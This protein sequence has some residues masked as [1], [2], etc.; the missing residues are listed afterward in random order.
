[1]RKRLVAAVIVVLL[2]T[3]LTV[4]GLRPLF[5]SK[6]YAGVTIEGVHLGGIGRDE[7]AQLLTLWQKQQQTR[8]IAVYYGDTRFDIDAASIDF[9]LDVDATVEEVWGFGRRGP[10]WERLKNIYTAGTEGY[11]VPARFK[12]NEGKLEQLISEWKETIDRPSR[13]ATF[14][15]LTGGVIPQEPGRK[16][17]VTALKPMLIKALKSPDTSSVALPVTPVYP[18]I[19]VADITQTGIKESMSLYSTNFNAKEANRTT[20]IRMAARKIN[21]HIVYPGQVFS[22]NET[23]GPRDL[24]HGFKEALEIVDGEFVPGI[25]GGVCQVSS[26]LYNAVLLANLRVIERVNHSKPLGYVEAGRD[27]TVAYGIID[28]KFANDTDGPVMIMAEVTGGK[29]DIGVFGRQRPVEKVEVV[30][31]DK[32]VIPPMVVKKQDQ[33]M[34][35]GETKI[36]KQGKPGCEVTVVRV[37]RRGG[38]EVRR[39]MLG[40]DRYLPENT[41]VKVGTK[42]PPFVTGNG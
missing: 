24:E 36:D 16:L 17:E 3:G 14:S 27:A 25:G 26:T 12:Y 29:L 8:R 2:G 9:D 15:M 28:F 38:V 41:I 6:V 18:E 23:V 31:V 34:F 30:A 22:F 40:K 1:M 21:G 37:V 10:W 42:L 7:A 19:T 39:E 5:W 35:L 33:E 11:R 20:N 32:Q 4:S 13:N